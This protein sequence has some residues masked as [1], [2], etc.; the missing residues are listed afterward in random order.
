MDA[1]LHAERLDAAG[2]KATHP[3]SLTDLPAG[4]F[5]VLDGND[6]PLLFHDGLLW[7][8]TPDGYSTPFAPAPD[9]PPRLLTPPSIVAVVVAGYVPTVHPSILGAT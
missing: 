2:A 9:A 4:V 8:W 6:R 5:V 7:P 3:A 1:R